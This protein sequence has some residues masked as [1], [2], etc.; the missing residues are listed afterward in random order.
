MNNDI[1]RTA[2]YSNRKSIRRAI[3][4]FCV[5]KNITITADEFE[6][7]VRRTQ[8][9]G[10]ES[11]VKFFATKFIGFSNWKK[12]QLLYQLTI[13]YNTEMY[14][15]SFP[16]ANKVIANLL[17]GVKDPDE[18]DFFKNTLFDIVKANLL[19]EAVIDK[20]VP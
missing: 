9:S 16:K 5:L 20:Y 15:K 11:A 14:V 7:V 4:R 13:E 17:N 2:A 1:I 18:Y 6:T 8:E 10:Y 19:Q 12:R 3:A